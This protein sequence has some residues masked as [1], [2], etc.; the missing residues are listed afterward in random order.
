MFLLDSDITIW[1]LRK[2]KPVIKA[3][4]KLLAEDVTGISTITIAEVYKNIFPEEEKDTQNFIYKQAVFDVTTEVAKSAGR[5][6]QVHNKKLIGMSIT[7]CIVAAT[8]KDQKATLVTL[9]TK[10]FPMSDIKILNP[11]KK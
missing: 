5:Y 11:L 6:W 9:N 3:V 7:D 4:E 1:L 8:A 2:N 10:H